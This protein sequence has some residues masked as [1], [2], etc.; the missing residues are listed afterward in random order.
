M[1]QLE[2]PT[3]WLEARKVKTREKG[4]TRPPN[5]FRGDSKAEVSEIQGVKVF[6]IK[7][8]PEGDAKAPVSYACADPGCGLENDGDRTTAYAWR[9][10]SA[11]EPLPLDFEWQQ[12]SESRWNYYFG[13]PD[14]AQC[15]GLG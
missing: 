9:L 1:K 3:D 8:W 2:S 5:I 4:E 10:I 15:L 7:A 6:R 14:G 13:L 11:Q 12:S